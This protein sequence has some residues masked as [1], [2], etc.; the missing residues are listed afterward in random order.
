MTK[1]LNAVHVIYYWYSWIHWCCDFIILTWF[2][3]MDHQEILM[4]VL[5]KCRINDWIN[6]Y[7]SA[8]KYTLCIKILQGGNIQT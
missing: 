2:I 5:F 7:I 4:D 3:E 6:F 8:R 1:P